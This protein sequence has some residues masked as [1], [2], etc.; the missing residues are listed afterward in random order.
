MS[1]IFVGTRCIFAPVKKNIASTYKGEGKVDAWL[2]AK[3]RSFF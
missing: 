3:V 1:R 2:L